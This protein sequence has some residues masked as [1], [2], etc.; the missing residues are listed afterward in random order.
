[1]VTFVCCNANL[2]KTTEL[3]IPL[4]IALI[5]SNHASILKSHSGQIHHSV[6]FQS[7]TVIEE[8]I[9]KIT[10]FLMIK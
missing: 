1:M 4:L 8:A 6:G 10:F 3:Y 2:N 7:N 9:L 5:A